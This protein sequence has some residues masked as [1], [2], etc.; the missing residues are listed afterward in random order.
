MLQFPLIVVG[1]S[2]GRI[3][4][5]INLAK[6]LPADFRAAVCIVIHISAHNPSYFPEILARAGP[7]PATHAQHLGRIESGHVYCAPPRH[8]LLIENGHFRI[9]TGPKENG[10]RPAIDPLFRSAAHQQGSNV[11]GVVMSGM[12]DDG[13]SGLW[14]I[15]HS[16]GITVVQDPNDAEYDSMPRS[17]LNHVD[18]DYTVRSQN[19]ASL[20]IDLVSESAQRR[21]DIEAAIKEHVPLDPLA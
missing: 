19:L 7:L 8:H 15:R 2:A 18:A 16:G 9:T 20:M 3:Q 6:G 21:L 10:V 5:L 17:A 1:G 13:A 11:I 4:P 14:A 12:L